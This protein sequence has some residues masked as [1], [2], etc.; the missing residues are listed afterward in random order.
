M[1]K[2]LY[3]LLELSQT[4]SQEA[5]GAAYHRLSAKI[6]GTDEDAEN[7]RKILDETFFTLSQPA[8]RER[9]DKTL[10]AANLSSDAAFY[11]NGRM[12]PITKFLLILFLIAI[13]GFSY[14]KY[15]KD[16]EAAKLE[17][18]RIVAEERIAALRTAEELAKLQAD[19]DKR[20]EELRLD[21]RQHYET[22]QA[23]NEAAQITRNQAYAMQQI[24]TQRQRE[25]RELENNQRREQ[26]EAQRR[27][28][29]DKAQ[30]RQLESENS[31][32]RRFSVN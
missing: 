9:Y 11:D 14:A 18:E 10:A 15:S 27:L 8:R 30:L 7:R 16:K 24:E 3:D 26:F 17:R 20:A 19:K 22:I 2:T 31:R 12:Q 6:S 29:R 32:F 21:Q 13:C 1:K 25:Q 4:A 5:V 28:E 23:R